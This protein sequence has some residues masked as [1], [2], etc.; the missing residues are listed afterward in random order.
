LNPERRIHRL[1]FN[2]ELGST[3]AGIINDLEGLSR[4][5]Q[6]TSLDDGF[7]ANSA[8]ISRKASDPIGIGGGNAGKI[9]SGL[10][11]PSGD[12]VRR[13][14]TGGDAAN[15][16]MPC[17]GGMGMGMGFSSTSGRSAHAH[18]ELPGGATEE[19]DCIAGNEF[20]LVDEGAPAGG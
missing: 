9:V 7:G 5:R 1:G 12:P 19:N 20:L 11:L 4:D 3:S 6:S 8:S 13:N 15:R 18:A 17:R 10:D 16:Q 14:R 2:T